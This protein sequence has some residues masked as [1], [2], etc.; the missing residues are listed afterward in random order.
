M[1]LWKGG[2]SV[3]V[4]TGA[5][6]VLGHAFSLQIAR[7]VTP[8]SHLVLSSRSSENLCNL[9][10]A[11][12][13]INQDVQVSTLEWDLN[14]PDFRQYEDELQSVTNT[15]RNFAGQPIR[16]RS[17]NSFHSA[18]LIHCAAEIGDYS[19]TV[20]QIGADLEP[21]KNILNVNVVSL[22]A[23]STAFLNT[24]GGGK[25]AMYKAIV[26]L[27]APCA[28]NAYASFGHDAISKAAKKMAL[29]VLSKER[30]DVK[31]GSAFQPCCGGITGFL[32]NTRSEPRCGGDI[33]KDFLFESGA[34]IGT[35]D[36]P[37]A[38]GHRSVLANGI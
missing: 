8:G 3:V 5:T 10:D 9:K 38:N 34:V 18:V 29:D 19:K 30:P 1:D 35:N 36:V 15:Q 16:L 11:I 14:N 2:K 23:V 27:T 32:C 21:L 20:Q 26:N 22:L 6:G 28:E 13:R 37:V 25:A 4:V 33:L 31:A 17:V 12:L 24:F 7:L